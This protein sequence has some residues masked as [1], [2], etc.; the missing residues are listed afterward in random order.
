MSPATLQ[1]VPADVAAL[2][3]A[4]RAVG[5]ATIPGCT[6]K[7]R[8][9]LLLVL[10]QDKAF[11]LLLDH[12][13]RYDR[14]GGDYRGKDSMFLAVRKGDLNLIVSQHPAYFRAFSLAHRLC[15][16]AEVT[17]KDIRV[18]IHNALVDARSGLGAPS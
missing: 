8:D 14:Y 11:D 5:S 13:F 6:P 16:A 7:D 2:V 15:V 9:L 18:F 3:T 1:E 10:D 12:G 17:D 4:H